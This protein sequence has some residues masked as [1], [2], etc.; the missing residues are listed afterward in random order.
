M[1]GAIPP[2]PQYVFM[3]WCSVKHRDNFTFIFYLT[4]QNCTQ[5]E[6]KSRL[7]LVNACYRSVLNILSSHLLSK[8]FKIKI[9]KSI[10]LPAVL[11][12]CETWSVT[13]REEHGLRVSENRVLRK[14]LGPKTGEV[15]GGWRRQHNE[16]HNLYSSFNIIRVIKLEVRWAGHV[17]GTLIHE[18][19]LQYYGRK[20]RREETTWKI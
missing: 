13:L 5:E 16:F 12:G 11:Y 6:I 20:T 17:V 8:N 1:R 18:T 19:C 4:D 3:A 7:N 2:L 9:Y 14:M 10:M 15:A